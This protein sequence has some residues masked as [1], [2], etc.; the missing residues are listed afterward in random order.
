MVGGYIMI[1]CTGFDISNLGAVSG[2]FEKIVNAYNTKKNIILCNVE[3]DGYMLSAVDTVVTPQANGDYH[4]SVDNNVYNIT[5][6][7]VVSAVA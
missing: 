5:S 7:D 1:D 2:L 6:A 4:F 3:N